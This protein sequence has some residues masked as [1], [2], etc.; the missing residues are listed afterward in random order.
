MKP[1]WSPDR[2]RELLEPALARL[3]YEVYD[4]QVLGRDPG[5]IV[6]LT[7][8]SEPGIS[9]D[10]CERAS[11]IVSA[12]LD[13]ADPFNGRYTLEV[14]SPGAERQL[15]S[16]R[17]YQRQLGHTVRVRYREGEGEAVLQGRLVEVGPS[18]IALEHRDAVPQ[19]VELGDVISASRVVQ[20]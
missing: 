9:L 2:L 5:G 8:D 7:L 14:S 11:N 16:Q 1:G 10:D 6:R 20:I 3:G 12:V 13:Q 17:D 15:E 4:L 19:R 18:H